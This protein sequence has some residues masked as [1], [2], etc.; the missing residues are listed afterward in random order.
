M[1]LF[2]H[3]NGW[4]LFYGTLYKLSKVT[5]KYLFVTTFFIFS[6]WTISKILSCSLF[7]IFLACQVSDTYRHCPHLRNHWPKLGKKF[8]EGKKNTISFIKNLISTHGWETRIKDLL[9]I[10]IFINKANFHTVMEIQ[11]DTTV[12]WKQ[13]H[14]LDSFLCSI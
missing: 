1:T 11:V 3:Q 2:L 14:S 6:Y 5:A 7:K 13:Y 10:I 8:K 4:L 12:H 9:S